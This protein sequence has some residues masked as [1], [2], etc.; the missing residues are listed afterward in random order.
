MSLT[1]R[2]VIHFPLSLLSSLFWGKEEECKRTNRDI[3]CTLLID[4]DMR[5]FMTFLLHSS[6]FPSLFW[7]KKRNVREQIEVFTVIY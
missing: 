3:Y 7:E 6:S 4:R 2:F 1:Q 5:L